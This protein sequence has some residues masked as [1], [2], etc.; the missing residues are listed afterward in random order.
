MVLSNL[1]INSFS[2]YIRTSG[3]QGVDT[4]MFVDNSKG[5]NASAAI[6]IKMALTVEFAIDLKLP[7]L[8]AADQT[9]IAYHVQLIAVDQSGIPE[10]EVVDGTEGL[11]KDS[12][13]I[14]RPTKTEQ[15]SSSKFNTDFVG[16]Y[17]LAKE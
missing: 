13:Q 15:Y 7:G 12:L 5:I 4:L 6:D 10:I 14:Q 3:M 17:T 9:K 8:S 11:K 2:R 16:E 1:S